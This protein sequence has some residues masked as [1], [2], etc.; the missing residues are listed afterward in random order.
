MTLQPHEGLNGPRPR[1]LAVTHQLGLGGAQLYLIDLLRGIREL[2]AYECTVV[3]PEDGLLREQLERLGV[4][5]HVTSPFPMHD[6]DAYASR[7]EEF[8]ALAAPAHFDVVLVNTMLAFP[9][10]DIAARLG[11]PAV[12]AIHESYD[13]R[14]L[15]WMFGPGLHPVVKARAQTA[16]RGAAV[17][18]FEADATRALYGPYVDPNR[19]VTLPYG[20]DFASLDAARANFDLPSA[21]RKRSIPEDAQVVLCVGTIEPRKAQVPLAQ[22][23]GLIA[24]RHPRARL[25]FVGGRDD[26]HTRTLEEYVKRCA[27]PGR[28]DVVPVTPDVWSWY[29]LA[30]VLVSASDVESLPRSVLEAMAWETPILATS[31]FGLPELITDGETGWLCAPRD[32]RA[33]ADALDA[34][35]A[36]PDDARLQIGAAGR[37]LVLER[38]ALGDYA[39]ACVELLARAGEAGR[40][41]VS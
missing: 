33:L 35:L 26:H 41:A 22:A 32:V 28:V 23:F 14:I 16:L 36:A 40:V 37:A 3:S 34:V 20:L 24:E 15:W 1:L 38:H 12:W 25:V 21:R 7:I 27:P 2:D 17:A 5:V 19:C 9:G 6:A 18:L 29:G 39:T 8:A 10:A 13:P 31:V 4:R 30:D 11:V